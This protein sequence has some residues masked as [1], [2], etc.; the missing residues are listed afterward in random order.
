MHLTSKHSFNLASY[1]RL[2]I[3]FINEQAVDVYYFK[4]LTHLQTHLNR[5]RLRD[6][7]T[8]ILYYIYIMYDS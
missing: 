4:L 8:L 3:Y 5:S 2:L 1:K 6:R 7:C